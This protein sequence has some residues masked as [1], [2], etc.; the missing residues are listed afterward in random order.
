[1]EDSNQPLQQAP[2]ASERR[3]PAGG[4]EADARGDAQSTVRAPV[5]LA[6]RSELAAPGSSFTQILDCSSGTLGA[7]V[8]WRVGCPGD[9]GR[10]SHPSVPKAGGLWG[11]R[12]LTSSPL[13]SPI[14]APSARLH[15]ASW[16][17][18]GPGRAHHP[19]RGRLRG[20]PGKEGPARR[21]G[22]GRGGPRA[23]WLGRTPLSFPSGRRGGRGAGRGAAWEE[24]EEPEPRRRPSSDQC[25]RCP[26]V[27]SARALP[28][29]RT[30]TRTGSDAAP[31]ASRAGA[32]RPWRTR[33]PAA[34]TRGPEA[35]R[36]AGSWGCGGAGREE[37]AR[38]ASPAPRSPIA[39][40]GKQAEPRA[41]L[42]SPLPPLRSALRRGRE[43]GGWGEPEGVARRS[44]APLARWGADTAARTA[45]PLGH[46][47][48]PCCGMSLPCGAQC[49]SEEHRLPGPS[50]E[51]SAGTPA[52]AI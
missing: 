11:Q 23:L 46:L 35:A 36:G 2:P 28:R 41:R 10:T 31:G 6:S 26:A 39:V 19:G 52:L 42:P 17:D 15:P 20:E 32:A 16:Q 38:S 22:S 9:A 50:P 29:T 37:G 13:L 27:Q 49:E 1:M 40:A 44:R 45:A 48:A 5:L 47:A 14:R 34:A 25:S 7:G 30:G 21:G 24:R 43:S 3:S 12:D 4:P 51:C 8:L 33:R 18:T